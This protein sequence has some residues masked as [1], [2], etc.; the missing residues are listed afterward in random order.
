MFLFKNFPRVWASRAVAQ[1]YPV[2]HCLMYRRPTQKLEL[3][4]CYRSRA[5]GVK[6]TTTTTT[7]RRRRRTIWN[8]IIFYCMTLTYIAPNRPTIDDAA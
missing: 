2:K 1:I 8:K 4:M 7:V 3:P 6:A 5:A